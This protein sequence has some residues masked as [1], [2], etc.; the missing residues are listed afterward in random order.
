MLSNPI[1]MDLVGL[2]CFN[3]NFSKSYNENDDDGR[4]NTAPTFV[5]PVVLDVSALRYSKL[6][7]IYST[8]VL[9]NA[10]SAPLKLRFDIPSNT[11]QYLIL[12]TLGNSF[13][14]HYIWLKLVV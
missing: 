2:T 12:Y 5:V 9:L 3:A 6:I 4:M 1:S 8:V 14:F 11:S 10:T 13:H 7:R